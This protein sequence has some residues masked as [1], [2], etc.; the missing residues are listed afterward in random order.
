MAG[1][2]PRPVMVLADEVISVRP[3]D[4]AEDLALRGFT[5]AHFSRGLPRVLLLGAGF[6]L[7]T[8]KYLVDGDRAWLVV[9]VVVGAVFAEHL[10]IWLG[11][12][13]RALWLRRDRALGK[14]L[15][16]ESPRGRCERLA[17]SGLLWRKGEANAMWRSER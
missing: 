7:V 17:A 2:Q 14:M 9:M 11:G 6:T 15:V 10:H 3:L 8:A 12:L 4:A 1:D 13:R 5:S 16:L